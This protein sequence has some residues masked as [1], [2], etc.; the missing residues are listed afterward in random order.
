MSRKSTLKKVERELERRLQR[1]AQGLPVSGTYSDNQV[2][3]RTWNP[4]KWIKGH[5]IFTFECE[6]SKQHTVELILHA[7]KIFWRLMQPKKGRKKHSGVIEKN[8]HKG[9]LTK[10]KFTEMI[11]GYLH[12]PT[13]F[14]ESKER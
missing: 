14:S 2:P 13:K 7:R 8:L 6:C 10:E 5:R 3:T 1:L 4:S 11:N 12:E 9:D